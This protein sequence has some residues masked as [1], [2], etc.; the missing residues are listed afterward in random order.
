M[1]T[2]VNRTKRR[3]I[4][5][6]LDSVLYEVLYESDNVDENCTKNNTDFI[7]I[8]NEN[9]PVQLPNTSE[10]CPAKNKNISIQLDNIPET[11]IL[12]STDNY[13]HCD[14]LLIPTRVPTADLC[15]E[16]KCRLAEW[17]VN[18]NVPQNTINGLLPIFKSIPGLSE[19]P[20]DS[21]TILKTETTLERTQD[22]KIIEPGFYYHF[23]LGSAIEQH[24]H[25]T[26]IGDTDV[27][28]V[29]IG[30]DGL[31]L[32]KSSCSQFW[33]IL[34]Y[35][36]PLQNLV[37]PIGIY[38]GHEKPKDSNEFLRDFV[39]EVNTLMRFGININGT[40]KQVEIDGFSLDA[41][42]KSFG[43]PDLILVPDVLTHNDYISRK[44]E[45]HH[46][47]SEISILSEL[48]IDVTCLFGLDYMHLTCLGIM[49]KLIHLWID[50]G[51]LNVRLPSLTTKKLSSSLLSLRCFI[52]CEFSRKPR[53]LCD[54]NRYKATEFRQILIYTGPI[55]FKNILNNDCYKHFMALNIA[56]T[57][58]LSNNMDNY[59]EY[60]QNLLNYF[61]QNFEPLYG[62]HLMS[63]NVH[64][65][66]HITD[67][68][69]KFG[70]LDNIAAFPF[71]NY[72]KQLKK[73]IR[74]HDK[75]LQQI[76]KRLNEKNSIGN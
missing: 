17:A 1:E 38:W 34:G 16:V 44:H 28:K 66:S 68:Y 31:P 49:R 58:L 8:Q 29:V 10:I 4:R 36:R 52:P 73:M 27:I 46:V 40:N 5:E 23:G 64:G 70:L 48:P 54:L 13:S 47:G 25:H 50:K 56:M 63:F 62:R 72:L 42:A 18:F 75:P 6:E 22:L 24:F 19:M 39:N 60:A 12:D 74:K 59:L 30:I 15:S 20:I 53:G 55:I 37:F 33:P 51:P 71:E 3:R 26:D 11:S 65:L 43:T 32:S 2:V 69:K 57:I 41:P 45:E 67:D 76:I 35:I 7:N 9:T 14:S 61:I 21:R